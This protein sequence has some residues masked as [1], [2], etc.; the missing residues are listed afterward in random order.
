MY[1]G[2]KKFASKSY[3]SA[4]QTESVPEVGSPVQLVSGGRRSCGVVVETMGSRILIAEPM[5]SEWKDVATW[6]ENNQHHILMDIVK[7]SGLTQARQGTSEF[8]ISEFCFCVDQRWHR[9]DNLGHKTRVTAEI[10]D[11]LVEDEDTSWEE[12]DMDDIDIR[13][14]QL[15]SVAGD[16]LNENDSDGIDETDTVLSNWSVAAAEIQERKRIADA[17][18]SEEE[19][20]ARWRSGETEAPSLGILL[21][22]GGSNVIKPKGGGQFFAPVEGAKFEAE[23]GLRRPNSKTPN[24]DVSEG[25]MIVTWTDDAPEVRSVKRGVTAADLKKIIDQTKVPSDDDA[26]EADEAINVNMVMVPPN[27]PL[28]DGDMIF[29][30]ETSSTARE[31]VRRTRT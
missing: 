12:D 6:M 8:F 7:E 24:I 13:I 30:N 31:I 22:Q 18:K 15:Q 28:K 21:A 19:K 3:Q 14:R 1:K 11:T 23:L 27:T 4:M 9:V 26:V 20:E 17:K 10:V 25:V 16:L 2:K 29:L 5:R